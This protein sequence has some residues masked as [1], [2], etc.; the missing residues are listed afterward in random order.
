MIAAT[1]TFAD[2]ICD[3]TSGGCD[4][5]CCCDPDCSAGIVAGWKLIK[6]YC[7]NEINDQTILSASQCFDRSVTGSLSDL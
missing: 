2:C 7:L 6:G 1:N 5:A 3:L 4:P